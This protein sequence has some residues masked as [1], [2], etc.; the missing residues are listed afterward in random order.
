MAMREV[1]PI[2]ASAGQ[3]PRLG[4]RLWDLQHHHC[5]EQTPRPDRVPVIDTLINVGRP[6][7]RA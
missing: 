6:L 7:H 5:S 2:I 4:A 3:A 1:G